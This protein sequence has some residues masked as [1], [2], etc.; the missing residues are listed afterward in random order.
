MT[1]D[2][3]ITRRF[4]FVF[5]WLGTLLLLNAAFRPLL[6]PAAAPSG[7]AVGIGT[8]DPSD[9]A[10]GLIRDAGIG[11]LR[12]DIRWS[13]VE[14][15]RNVYAMSGES[16]RIVNE[17]LRN[18]I[19][20]LLILCYG[21]QFYDNGLYPVSPEA[22]EGFARFAE[23]AVRHFKGRVRYY[24]VWNEWNVG[25]GVSDN[26]FYGAPA[27]YVALLK[28]V[29]PR[30]KQIDPG[31]TVIGGVISGNGTR[32]GWMEAA[33]RLGLLD[34]LDALSY[35]PYCYGAPG[36]E[37]VPD[38]GLMKRIRQNAGI[39][40]RYQKRDTPVFL[41]E[42]G[43]PTHLAQNGSS[44]Q[45][46]ARFLARS[47]LLARTAPFIKGLWWYDF[48]DDGLDRTDP[49]EN[50]GIVA[51]DLTPKPAYAA[52]RD[53]CGLFAEAQ[54]TGEVD[55]GP[56]IR[57]LKFTAPSG[58]ASW[59]AWA[60]D[61][62]EDWEVTFTRRASSQSDPPPAPI[63]QMGGAGTERAWNRKDDL[64]TLS[65][66]LSGMPLV[67][68]TGNSDAQVSWHRGDGQAAQEDAR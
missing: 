46:E 50:Y 57:I 52:M 29:Y 68:D 27:P 21:N 43:W 55:A 18:G 6:Q 15:T 3:R 49:E 42:L 62:T 19:Q 34:H 13:Q 65:V 5:L 41:T 36:A 64:L 40:R 7:F 54:Y 2:K 67:I 10:L 39:M 60:L 58:E 51:H 32:D 4:I 1:F 20:P 28:T 66:K 30:L 24:E 11:F 26:I 12:D 63:T 61:D 16:D 48:S 22:V 35:H 17:A 47:F 56:D 45:D 59:V 9:Q 33:C 53:V 38:I 23:F 31:I 25:T 8:H 37:R 44:P 14:Q